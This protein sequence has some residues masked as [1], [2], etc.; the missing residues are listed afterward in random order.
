MANSIDYAVLQDY[1]IGLVPPRE[2]EMQKMEE[3]GNRTNFPII[4]PAAGYMCYLIARLI[5]AHSVFEMGSGY[6]YSTAWFAKAVVENGGGVVHHVVWDQKLSNMAAEHL[7]KL[8]YEDIVQYHVGEAVTHLKE[9]EGPFDLIFCDIEKQDYP[10]ALPVI[11]SR[12]RPAGVLLID[13]II[14]SGRVFDKNDQSAQTNGVREFT[15]MI[16][17]DPNWIVSI[18]PIRDGVMVAYKKQ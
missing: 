5:G 1:L 13:N 3:Y 16:T 11:A 9:V 12:L 18:M 4:G 15:R 8:G 17:Q 7:A 6:G 14:W 2:P 10:A